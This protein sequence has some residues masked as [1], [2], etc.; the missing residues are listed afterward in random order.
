M[1]RAWQAH[2]GVGYTSSGNGVQWLR[3]VAVAITLDLATVATTV[4]GDPVQFWCWSS[5]TRLSVVSKL[6][7]HCTSGSIGWPTI[8]VTR[9]IRK[10]SSNSGTSGSG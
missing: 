10:G 6:M 7:R 3:R 2:D 8:H 9:G 1:I 4:A 5:S